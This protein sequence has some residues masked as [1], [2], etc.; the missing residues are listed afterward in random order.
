MLALIKILYQVST[1]F[2]YKLSEEP[3]FSILKIKWEGGM[4]VACSL[5]T[6]PT[7]KQDNMKTIKKPDIWRNWN[8]ALN[9]PK[10]QTLYLGGGDAFLVWGGGERPRLAPGLLKK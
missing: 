10:Y 8:Q 3:V 2:P 6:V 4:W 5:P 7:Q 1:I 9:Y